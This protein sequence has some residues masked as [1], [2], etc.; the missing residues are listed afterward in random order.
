MKNEL[1]NEEHL[2]ESVVISVEKVRKQ[3][4]KI[5]NWKAPGKDGIQGYWIKNLSNLH[6]RIAIQM[7][8]ILMGEDSPPAWMAHGRTVLCQKDPRRGNV[9]ENYRP[10]TC[11]PLMWKRLTGMIAEGP[12]NYLEREK[13]LPE[14]QKGCKRGSHGTKDQL[15]IDKTVLKDCKKRHTNLSMA[16]VDYKKAY[17]F[18]P[19]SWI[20]ECME[21]FGIAENV[22][23]LL[24]KSME[25]WKLSLTSNGEDLG[26]VNVRRGIFQ[27]D[28]LSP[29]LPVCFEYGTIVVDT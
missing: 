27:G 13:L 24:K 2:Q 28:S 7:N 17:D 29:L 3:C 26:G 25:Q 12:C 22:R 8:K 14:E 4:R 23:N 5:P 21:M 9:A 1:E 6:E 11:L 10:I 16:W 18:V 20:N 15:L 19:H